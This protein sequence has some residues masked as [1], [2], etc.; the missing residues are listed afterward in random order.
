M[1]IWLLYLVLLKATV[2]AFAGLAS[3]PVVQDALVN[4]YH[5]LSEAQLNEAVVIT[6]STPGPV[7]LYVVSVGY[8]VAGIPGAMA[9]WL[10]MITPA[11]LIIPLVSL[12]G[13]HVEHP[14]AQGV[15]QTVVLASAGL[16]LAAALPLARETLVSP[17]TWAVAAISFVLLFV[18]KLDTLWI[19]LGAAAVSLSTATLGL[20]V[21]WA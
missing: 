3:L 2:T 20:A 13:R 19:I 9:G 1:S 8:F 10:A 5:V 6:R 21:R 12:S 14:R 4:H 17:V 15:L 11:L 18:T 16:L 7:G